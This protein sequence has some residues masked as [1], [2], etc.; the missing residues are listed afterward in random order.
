MRFLLPLLL[1]ALLAGGSCTHLDAPWRD[2]SEAITVEGMVSMRGNTPFA[3]PMLETADHALYVLK[4]ATLPN[5]LPACY[6]VTGEVYQDAW[7]GQPFAHL[8]AASVTP[9]PGDNPACRPAGAR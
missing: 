1:L 4:N 2:A 7:G 3:A 8:R 6:R 9:L 5:D